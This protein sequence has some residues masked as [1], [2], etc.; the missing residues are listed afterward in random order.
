MAMTRVEVEAKGPGY[1]KFFD[2]NGLPKSWFRDSGGL[3][4]LLSQAYNQ[5]D[6]AGGVPIEWHVAE[7]SVVEALTKLFRGSDK[8]EKIRII[9]TPEQP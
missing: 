8:L 9:Y 3:N 7:K 5:V 1:S 2:E 4:N 6:A